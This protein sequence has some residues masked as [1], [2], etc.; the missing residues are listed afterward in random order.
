MLL[1]LWHVWVAEIGSISKV[2][3]EKESL[4]DTLEN[5]KIG[6]QAVLVKVELMRVVDF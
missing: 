1:Y 6:V 5:A 4:A 2:S 3:T